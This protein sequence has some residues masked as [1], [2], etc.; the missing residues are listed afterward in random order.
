MKRNLLDNVLINN[1]ELKNKFVESMR[2]V[3]PI[4]AIVLILSITVVP[5]EPGPI[6]LFLF[7]AMLLILGMSLFTMGVD[8]SMMPMGEGLGATMAKSKNKFLPIILTFIL[9]VIITIAEP[10]LTVLANQIPTIDNF[11]IIIAVALGV[12]LFFAF[13]QLRAKWRIP[14]SKILIVFYVIAFVLAFFT[15]E[16]FIPA[17]FDAGGVTT[18]P[19]TVPFIMAFGVGLASL[20]TGKN[21]QS[22]S[23]GIVA[24]CSVGPIIAVL[25]L[26][27]IFNPS[28]VSPTPVTIPEVATTAD[29]FS[30]FLA[31]FPDYFAEVAIA[32]APIFA[33]FILFELITRRHKKHQLIR[34]I[35][36]FI[37]TYLGLTLFLTGVN[38]GFMPVGNLLGTK[39]ASSDAL[40]WLLI[41]VGALFG[42][43]IVAAEPAVH[44]LKKQV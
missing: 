11:I 29:A 18:G 40:K 21:S 9:G 25:I 37:Y 23:F 1:N 3:L 20:S 14:L 19:I 41:P 8:M 16:T 10:D 39:L 13:A 42:Y 36:G 27:I 43:F 35:S 38:V 28:Q 7:G 44:V 33:V 6:V 31:H 26:G 17:S 4:T 30:Y 12:G 22:D 15:P 32:L 24:M 2:A 34:I 5:I